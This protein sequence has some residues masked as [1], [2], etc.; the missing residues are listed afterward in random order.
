VTGESRVTINGQVSRSSGNTTTWINGVPQESARTPR[1]PA[2]ATLPG[3]E[4]EPSVSLRIGQTL[5]KIRGE[6]QDPV[7]NGSI[8]V[9]T[10]SGGGSR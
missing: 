7:Q 9:P 5:D 10:Q 3:G 8:V 2:Q 1:D 6:V 4:G